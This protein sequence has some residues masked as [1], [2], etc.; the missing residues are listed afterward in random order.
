[1]GNVSL[2][3][4]AF[5]VIKKTNWFSLV[6]SNRKKASTNKENTK[7]CVKTLE[8]FF[9]KKPLS[10]FCAI[11]IIYYFGENGEHYFFLNLC[12]HNYYDISLRKKDK[13]SQKQ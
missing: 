6:P 10:L 11:N 8:C 7:K 5:T 9:F 12:I 1:M 4:F 3:T 2:L 13:C